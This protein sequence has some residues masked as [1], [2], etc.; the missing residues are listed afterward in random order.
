MPELPLIKKEAY[1]WKNIHHI[2]HVN[3]EVALEVLDTLDMDAGAT[4]D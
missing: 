1:K 2:Y 3:R 4:I